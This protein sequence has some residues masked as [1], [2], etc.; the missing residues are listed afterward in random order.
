MLALALPAV[1]QVIEPEG[2]QNVGPAY[3][4]VR[5]I[6]LAPDAPETLYAAA[7]NPPTTASGLFKSTNGGGSWRLLAGAFPGETADVVRVDPR[8]PARVFATTVR[9][10]GESSFST[11][12]YR[13]VDGGA[14]W[15]AAADL[16]G[17][18]GSFAFDTAAAFRVYFASGAG[19]LYASEDTGVTWQLRTSDHR[20][21]VAAGPGG[22][23]YAGG[24]DGVTVLRSGDSGNNWSPLPPLPCRTI[25]FPTVQTLALD[26]EGRLYVGSGQTRMTFVDCAAVLRWNVQSGWEVVAPFA[27]RSLAFDPADPTRAYAIAFGPGYAQVRRTVDAGNSWDALSASGEFDAV[28]LALSASGRR[29]YAAAPTGIYRLD[30][31]K[32]RALDPR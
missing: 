14:T 28:E 27:A 32:P 6:S 10:T 30:I 25:Y 15:T 18:G 4:D 12:I 13:S 21:P 20:Y 1:G 2:W 11:R 29:L 3:E 23:L 7:T 16:E 19:P 31:R 26:S 24:P 22:W 17:R 9:P 8:V 5:S